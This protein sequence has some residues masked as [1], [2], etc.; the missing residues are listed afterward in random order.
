VPFRIKRGRIYDYL[1][2]ILFQNIYKNTEIEIEL[3]IGWEI[4][5]TQ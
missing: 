1:Q 4:H 3:L 2:D 5:A